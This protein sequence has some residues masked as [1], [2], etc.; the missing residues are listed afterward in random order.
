MEKEPSNVSIS[1]VKKTGIRR[2][3]ISPVTIFGLIIV[4]LSYL[5][6]LVI[7]N[8]LIDIQGETDNNYI[9]ETLAVLIILSIA[10][11]AFRKILKKPSKKKIRKDAK[12][13]EVRQ[14]METLL[15]QKYINGQRLLKA[16]NPQKVISGIH[17]LLEVAIKMPVKRQKITNL[18]LGKNQ[19]MRDHEEFLQSQN[20]ITW[21]LKKDLFLQLDQDLQAI[22][23]EVLIAIEKIIKQHALDFPLQDEPVALDLTSQYLPALNLGF[24][25]FPGQSI[26][27]DYA[28]CWQINFWQSQI[29]NISFKSTNL[30][31]ANFWKSTL[32]GVEFGGAKLREA[33]LK[34]NLT[35]ANNIAP[36]QFFLTQEWPVNIIDTEKLKIFFPIQSKDNPQWRIWLE[37]AK[38]RTAL[39]E[40]LNEVDI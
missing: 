21:R 4:I 39:L 32:S 18:L 24:I 30:Q 36:S 16:T 35:A 26:I 11:V 40:S 3:I 25:K 1:N 6:I 37:R 13:K 27:F 5:F 20:L 17:D 33:K 19:W 38:E 10:Y 28:F 2:K 31:G 15:H 34:T 9:H 14:K 12:E 29:S 22:S 8:L 7:S 23:L